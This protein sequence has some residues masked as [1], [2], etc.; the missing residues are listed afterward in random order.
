LSPRR[1]DF[2]AWASI[3]RAAEFREWS[4][5]AVHLLR[6][7]VYAD[8]A[9]VWPIVLAS[10][11]PLATY[12]ARLGLIL[13]I[14]EA[15]GLAFV[16]QITDSEQPEGYEQLPKL[17]R[18]TRLGYDA[19]LVCVLLREELRRYEEEEVH[20]ERCVVETDRL[21]EQWKAFFS[22]QADEVRQRRELLAA[23]RKLEDL[24]F[25][26][27]INDNPECWEVRR[28]LKARLPVSELDNL[29]RQLIAAAAGLTSK[30]SVNESDE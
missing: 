18:K 22:P 2:H 7:V 28:I 6:E 27:K 24:G 4:I 19:T 13:V 1:G 16:R 25:S 21:F 14:D 11:T 23:L 15:E 5:A 8:D 29:R 9:R 3:H 12:F 10:Q 20:N 30:E 26:R 17:I